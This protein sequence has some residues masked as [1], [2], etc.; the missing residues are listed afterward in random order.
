MYQRYKNVNGRNLA[1]GPPVDWAGL[2][3]GT[4]KPQVNVNFLLDDSTTKTI[5]IATGL[6]S[7]ALIFSAWLSRR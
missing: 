4:V 5:Y 3:S 7:T 6:V 1:D 2:I